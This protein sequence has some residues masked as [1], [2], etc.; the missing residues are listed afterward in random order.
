MPMAV[1]AD[2]SEPL[3]RPPETPRSSSPALLTVVAGLSAGLLTYA[4]TLAWFDDECYNLLAAQLVNAGKRPYLDFFY[5]QVPLYAYVNAGWFRLFGD[6]WRSAHA[7]SALL[8]SGSILLVAGFV[9]ARVPESDWRLGTA[10]TAGLLVGLNDLVIQVGTIGQA[11][12]LVLFLIVAAFRLVIAAVAREGGA[13]PFW[14]GLCAGAAAASSLLAAPVAPILLLWMIR[15]SRPGERLKRG[16]WFLGGAALPFLPVLW[17]AVQGP[18]QTLFN[19]VEYHLFYRRGKW[20][21]TEVSWWD[22]RNFYRFW[23]ESAQGLSLALLA[24]VGLLFL[25]RRTDWK[26]EHRAEFALCAWLTGG[27]GVYVAFT[28][29]GLLSYFAL[30]IPFLGILASV[31]VYAIGSRVWTSGW[32]G[33][34][35]MVFVGLYALGL[36]PSAYRAVQGGFSPRWQYYE[37]LGRE[38][39]RV[40]PNDGEVGTDDECVYVAARR[41]PPAG[42]ENPLPLYMLE[43]RVPAGLAASLRLVPPSRLDER[44]AA[45][46]FATVVVAPG[47][48]RIEKFGLPR[49]YA[50][51]TQVGDYDIFWG[52]VG[53]GREPR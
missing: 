10:I 21:L 33:W 14:A 45:G 18:R 34:P 42:L 41:I 49:L 31:G 24:T 3:T 6:S 46:Y 44:L 43:G 7:L 22:L 32:R 19:I 28:L 13:L 53:S 51:R 52:R 15:R 20:P 47:D 37:N 2:A 40:T 1:R 8:T 29:P 16:A 17:L 50:R 38:V 11:Y 4:L 30:F 39:N 9:F 23:F 35:I 12:G 26:A 27:L 5:Q 48:P 25:A 36:A